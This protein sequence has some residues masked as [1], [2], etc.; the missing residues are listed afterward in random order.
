MFLGQSSNSVWG[1]STTI[2]PLSSPLVWLFKT[3]FLPR[4]LEVEE[5]EDADSESDVDKKKKETV[6]KTDDVEMVSL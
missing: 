4:F 5:E 3:K 1:I 2:S 6:K